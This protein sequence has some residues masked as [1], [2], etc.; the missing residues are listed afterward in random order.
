MI[1]LRLFL[2]FLFGERVQRTGGRV[3]QNAPRW[4][5]V[6]RDEGGVRRR[7][8]DDGRRRGARTSGRE[9][10]QRDGA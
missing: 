5:A 9:P 6:L 7:L 2:K 4:D 1:N 3:H 8:L 10:V